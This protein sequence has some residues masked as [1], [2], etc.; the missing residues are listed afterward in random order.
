MMD[1]EQQ[2]ILSQMI[3]NQ[4]F[5]GIPLSEIDSEFMEMLEED[6]LRD[7]YIVTVCSQLDMIDEFVATKSVWSG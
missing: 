7:L 2:L 3:Q 4:E 1:K 6:E 5:H